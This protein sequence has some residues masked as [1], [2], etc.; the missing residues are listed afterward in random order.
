MR[1]ERKEEKQT[2]LLRDFP[3]GEDG[4]ADSVEDNDNLKEPGA[5]RSKDLHPKSCSSNGTPPELVILGGSL[6]AL[7][8]RGL[9]RDF[10]QL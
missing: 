7:R 2:R 5:R 10:P 3:V 6:I 1:D 4:W 8:A 9:D